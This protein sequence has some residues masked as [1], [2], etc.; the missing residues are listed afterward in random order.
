MATTATMEMID[1]KYVVAAFR[2]FTELADT[3]VLVNTIGNYFLEDG[4]P[5]PVAYMRR[6]NDAAALCWDPN[7]LE[8]LKS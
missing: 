7:Y 3:K 8:A 4:Q 2:S 6:L 1:G 5:L